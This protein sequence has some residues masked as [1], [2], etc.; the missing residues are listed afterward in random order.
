MGSPWDRRRSARVD[1]YP[2]FVQDHPGDFEDYPAVGKGNF[3]IVED[4]LIDHYPGVVEDHPRPGV[5]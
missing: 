1:Y 5:G 2:R 4:Q 3:E